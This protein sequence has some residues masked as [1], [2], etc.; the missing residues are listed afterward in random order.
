M[1]D[2]NDYLTRKTQGMSTLNSND[3]KQL[4]DS[5]PQPSNALLPSWKPVHD[6]KAT[7]E[8]VDFLIESFSQLYGSKFKLDSESAYIDARQGWSWVV[9]PFAPDTL[10]RALT[11]WLCPGQYDHHDSS[12]PPTPHAFFTLCRSIDPDAVK[13]SSTSDQS[14]QNLLTNLK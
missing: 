12:W 6:P 7:S 9:K 11:K 10:K 1:N 3:L 14:V 2:I 13:I 5:T 4:P 8:L